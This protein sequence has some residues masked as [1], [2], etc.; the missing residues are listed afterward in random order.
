MY[1]SVYFCK[2]FSN[3]LQRT[4]AVTDTLSHLLVQYV[5]DLLYF[6]LK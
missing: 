6:V 5:E 4:P 2:Y 1:S 3:R